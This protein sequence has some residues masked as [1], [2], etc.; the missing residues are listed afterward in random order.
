MILILF[1]Y[2]NCRLF[3]ML[4]ENFKRSAHVAGLVLGSSWDRIVFFL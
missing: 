1:V 2:V 3:K 4:Q